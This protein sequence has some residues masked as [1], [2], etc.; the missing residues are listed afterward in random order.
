MA[1]DVILAEIIFIGISRSKKKG[2]GYLIYNTAS[3]QD[4]AKAGQWMNA[5]IIKQ[6]AWPLV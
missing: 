6:V 1:V 3:E 4:S 5:Y 2:S